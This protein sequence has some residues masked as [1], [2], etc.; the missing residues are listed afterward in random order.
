MPRRRRCMGCLN[1]RRDPR[2]GVRTVFWE[3]MKIQG[4]SARLDTTRRLCSPAPVLRSRGW[5]AGQ[6]ADMSRCGHL[7]KWGCQRS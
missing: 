3:L 7:A 6:D 5:Q 4:L 2:L 1:V